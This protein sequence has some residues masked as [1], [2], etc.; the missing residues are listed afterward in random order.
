MAPR[1]N[2]VS[3][4]AKQ[5]LGRKINSE[6]A[7][8]TH[9][10]GVTRFKQNFRSHVYSV[11]N[12]DLTQYFQTHSV[13]YSNNNPRCPFKV[14]AKTAEE[15]VNSYKCCLESSRSQH[16]ETLGSKP[17]YQPGG[18]QEK[19]GSL[20]P[21]QSGR[22]VQ[23][24]PSGRMECERSLL[25]ARAWGDWDAPRLSPENPGQPG[26]REPGSAHLQRPQQLL[27]EPPPM[28]PGRQQRHR[29]DPQPRHCRPS[30]LASR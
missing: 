30:R 6:V 12:L 21:V 2:Y 23:E 7:F 22:S 26:P 29:P 19:L 18:A 28:P 13:N 24:M 4:Q 10:N 17:E 1:V 8:L 9:Y 20:K 15:H 14:A 5:F 27:R 25:G 3:N 11:N 16:R